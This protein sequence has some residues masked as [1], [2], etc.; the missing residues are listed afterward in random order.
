MK[1]SNE[2]R[3][4]VKKVISRQ[5]VA[6]KAVFAES[7]LSQKLGFNS[8]KVVANNPAIAQKIKNRLF[9]IFFAFCEGA[10]VKFFIVTDNEA[11]KG[12]NNKGQASRSGWLHKEG[13]SNRINSPHVFSLSL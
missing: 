1:D 2:R 8:N 4:L 12:A 11:M 3:I 9:V 6:F 5:F 13:V 7:P 10:R